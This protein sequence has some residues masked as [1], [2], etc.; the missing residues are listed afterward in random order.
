MAVVWRPFVCICGPTH[1][2]PH[3]SRSVAA[4][5][6]GGGLHLRYSHRQ[7]VCRPKREYD[8]WRTSSPRDGT[9]RTIAKMWASSHGSCHGQPS[10]RYVHGTSSP[11]PS[12]CSC[13][14]YAARD[15]T[16][17]RWCVPIRTTRACHGKRRRGHHDSPVPRNRV[18]ICD[19]ERPL[20][21]HGTPPALLRGVV[22]VVGDQPVSFTNTA[23]SEY[24]AIVWAPH[25]ATRPTPTAI[26][27]ALR[28]SPRRA[29][30]DR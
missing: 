15:C 6:R 16:R 29:P 4:W 18:P 3:D 27:T 14:A 17:C 2:A 19:L 24:G 9:M 30:G 20:V 5:V 10:V 21:G 8:R 23:P 28:M 1:R 12:R 13:N 22:A 7:R 25:S 26:L 11:T